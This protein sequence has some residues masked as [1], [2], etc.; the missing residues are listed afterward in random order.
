MSPIKK[1]QYLSD[2]YL[3]PLMQ[4][5]QLP[6][7]VDWSGEFAI[8]NPMEVEIGFGMGEVLLSNSFE[9]PERNYVGIEQHWERIFKTLKLLDRSE[10]KRPN[11]RILDVDARLAFL[12][13]FQQK[14]ISRV[15]CLFPCPWPKKSHIK[16]RLFSADFLCLL[17]SRL[18]DNGEIYIVTDHEKYFRWILEEADNRFFDIKSRSIKPQFATKFEKK[19]HAQGQDTFF[20][21]T[22]TKKTH[23]EIPVDREEDMKSY[24]IK[25]FFIEAF[26]FPPYTE[27]VS[28]ICKDVFFDEKKQHALVYLI[29]TEQHLTQHIRVSIVKKHD[30]W[31]VHRTDGQTFFPT[32]GIVRAIELVYQAAL[33]TVGDNKGAVD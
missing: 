9:N 17:N 15:Y 25:D 2:S 28:V 23:K 29:V 8:Q 11:V 10:L 32:P 31:R 14:T 27:D 6:R 26:T 19:W 7:P 13:F 33:E 12:W 24:R 22:L 1:V 30:F 20:E 5:D 3:S 4:T 16:H 21:L 18:V